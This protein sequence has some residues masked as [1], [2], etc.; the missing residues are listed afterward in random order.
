MCYKLKIWYR[1]ISINKLK[2]KEYKTISRVTARD[3][4]DATFECPTIEV[5]EAHIY[6]EHGTPTR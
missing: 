5:L 2:Y 4:V 6:R 3:L 1:D